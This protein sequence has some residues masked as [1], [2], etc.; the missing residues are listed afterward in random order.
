MKNMNRIILLWCFISLTQS[1]S[2]QNIELQGISSIDCNTQTYC[3]SLEV[4]SGDPGTVFLGSSSIFFQYDPLAINYQSFTSATFDTS[5]NCLGSFPWDIHT[6]DPSKPGEF[7]M[8]MIL[9]NGEELNS[10]PELTPETWVKIGDVCFTIEDDTR[11][12]GI[13]FD[14]TLTS[15]NQN[16]LNNGSG[17]FAISKMQ[18]RGATCQPDFD[19]D[20]VPDSIDNCLDTSNPF[21]EDDDQDEQGNACDTICNISIFSIPDLTICKG[22]TAILSAFSNDGTAPYTYAWSNG[23]NE[24]NVEVEPTDASTFR[25]TITDGNGC[26]GLDSVEVAVSEGFLNDLIIYDID[27]G[28]AFDTIQNGDIFYLSSLPLNYNIEALVSGDVES[29]GFILSGSDFDTDTENGAPY[30][31]KSD[32]SPLNLDAGV[33]ALDT[34]IYSENNQL[35]SSCDS[36]LLNFTIFDDCAKIDLGGDRVHCEGDTTVIEADVTTTH[37]TYQLNWSTG[38]TAPGISVSPLVDEIYTVSITDNTHCTSEFSIEVEVTDAKITNFYIWDTSAD[39]IVSLI[40]EGDIFLIDQFPPSWNIQTEFTGGVDRV[41]FELRG[42]SIL[43]YVEYNIPYHLGGDNT[44]IDLGVGSYVLTAIPKETHNI[45]SIGCGPFTKT[46]QILDSIGCN[47]VTTTL[48]SLPGSL[49]YALTCSNPGETIYFDSKV[50]QDTIRLVNHIALIDKE[51]AISA[52]P[53]Q[54]IFIQ[55][56]GTSTVFNI[57]LNTSATIRGLHIIPANGSV[58][59]A[60]INEGTLTLEN[61]TIHDHPT[62]QQSE[63]IQTSGM[64]EVKGMVRVKRQE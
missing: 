34:R 49:N 45:N 14:P 27:S 4:K 11:W 24:G 62:Q 56:V 12:A 5:T 53:E 13:Q 46:F 21:Q 32:T 2:S 58:G 29:V 57:S 36:R 16:T 52:I 33:Y 54:M 44:N 50:F 7:S 20:G 41:D 19:L 51:V 39:T 40:Q 35:G 48:D 23:S 38:S 30:R 10:C 6:Y 3:L 42:D 1:I 25:V 8:T 28:L 22:S 37:G 17:A 63:V 59:S 26:I 31:Y 18:V 43:N 15:F 64:I 47:L 9:K 61:I 55:G 60:I